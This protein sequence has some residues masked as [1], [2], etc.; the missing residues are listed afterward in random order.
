MS[1]SPLLAPAVG[2]QQQRVKRVFII[3]LST[4]YPPSLP[5]PLKKWHIDLTQQCEERE[6]AIHRAVRYDIMRRR[7]SERLT[8]EKTP[9]I[10]LQ[11]LWGRLNKNVT[12]WLPI[13]QINGVSG[14]KIDIM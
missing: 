10:V 4:T 3:S 8:E 2:K 9:H 13:M 6:A 11:T 5:S 12:F 14:C 7:R 1:L